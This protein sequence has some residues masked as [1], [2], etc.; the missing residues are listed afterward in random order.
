LNCREEYW[1]RDVVEFFV[2]HVPLAATEVQ[3]LV[4]GFA[5]G[6]AFCLVVAV[7]VVEETALQKRTI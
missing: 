7:V 3:I 6:Y 4:S 2:A 1:F 5:F